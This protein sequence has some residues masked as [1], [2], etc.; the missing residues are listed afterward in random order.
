MSWVIILSQESWLAIVSD[1]LVIKFW[2]GTISEKESIY[3]INV[4]A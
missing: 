4:F 2:L 1:V 3:V